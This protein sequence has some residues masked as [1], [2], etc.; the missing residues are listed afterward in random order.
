MGISST[1]ELRTQGLPGCPAPGAAGS[2]AE[3]KKAVSS[4]CAMS[5]SS[6][7]KPGFMIT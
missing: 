3:I 4:G 5:Y 6:G 1:C 2:K 7:R